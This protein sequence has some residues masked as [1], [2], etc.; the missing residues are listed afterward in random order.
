M[1]V[2]CPLNIRL[3]TVRHKCSGSSPVVIRLS[4]S[5]KCLKIVLRSSGNFGPDLCKCSKHSSA[6]AASDTVEH[7]FKTEFTDSAVSKT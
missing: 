3:K 4:K 7:V 6:H 5:E 1:I 2:I